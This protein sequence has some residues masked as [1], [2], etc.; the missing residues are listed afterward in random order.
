L[1]PLDAEPIGEHTV[2]AASM[3]VPHTLA[4]ADE[5]WNQCYEDLMLR[6]GNRLEQEIARLGGSYAHV[7]EEHV[8][9]KYSGA[10]G[11][12]WL[13][14]RFRYVLYRQATGSPCAP[15]ALP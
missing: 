8:E 14:G 5:L 3:R 1:P 11:Q 13:D 4:H 7:L 10:T 6:V 9:S 12:G 15:K 2:E